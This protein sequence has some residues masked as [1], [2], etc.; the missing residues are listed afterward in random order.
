MAEKFH[1]SSDRAVRGIFVQGAD[2]MAR[3]ENT[4][5][6]A[7]QVRIAN[8]GFLLCGY[9]IG[10]GWWMRRWRP[11]GHGFWT[12]LW[13]LDKMLAF[14]Y[15]DE[16]RMKVEATTASAKRKDERAQLE[17][18]VLHA[19]GPMSPGSRSGRRERLESSGAQVE[20]SLMRAL[21]GGASEFGGGGGSVREPPRTPSEKAGV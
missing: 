3:W 10:R 21:F 4:E 16:A 1:V 7:Q 5:E 13:R 2:G 15:H 18:L 8:A 14:P 9:E 20:F 11:R 17:N 19:Q 12:P 6:E